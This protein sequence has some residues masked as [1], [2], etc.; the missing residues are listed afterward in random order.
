MCA[1]ELAST[2]GHTR[3]CGDLLWPKHAS[4]VP[5]RRANEPDSASLIRLDCG[6]GED[7]CR[8]RSSPDA[9]K[10]N[11]SQRGRRESSTVEH[12]V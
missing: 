6:G 8:L 1:R 3:L 12:A 10:K 4:G 7:E 11:W 5:C 9:T 2:V